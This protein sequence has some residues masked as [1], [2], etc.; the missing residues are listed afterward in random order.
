MSIEYLSTRY[1]SEYR[2]THV[3]SSKVGPYMDI[4][5]FFSLS[6]A[7][8]LSLSSRSLSFSTHEVLEGKGLRRDIDALAV[9]RRTRSQQRG[10]SRGHVIHEHLRRSTYLGN[11]Y[12]H[13]E[14]LFFIS[15][16]PGGRV[17]VRVG[18]F[19]SVCVCLC[20]RA[21]ACVR[22]HVYA[23]LCMSR[24]THVH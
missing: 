15:R 7:L 17:F 14:L 16:N 2:D 18:L 10:H 9:Y 6:L 12:L 8:A 13:R 21:H 19:P 4:L 11:Y 20:A 5:F 3:K 23:R 1:S 24:Y 22:M